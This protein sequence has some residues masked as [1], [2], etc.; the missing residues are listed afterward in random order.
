M[1]EILSQMI[2]PFNTNAQLP[3]LSR[4]ICTRDLTLYSH[5]HV[6]WLLRFVVLLLTGKR[7]LHRSQHKINHKSSEKEIYFEGRG[8]CCTSICKILSLLHYLYSS[9]NSLESDQLI[10]AAI[11]IHSPTHQQIRFNCSHISF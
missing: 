1:T 11:T 10:V 3:P 4:V 9:H 8:S 6:Q 7:L 2:D 5:P